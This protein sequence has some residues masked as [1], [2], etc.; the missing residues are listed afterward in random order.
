[1]I[2]ATD[3]GVTGFCT[4]WWG[5]PFSLQ[6]VPHS[7]THYDPPLSMRIPYPLPLPHIPHPLTHFDPA[8]SHA[9]TL[10]LSPTTHPHMP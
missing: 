9:D 6:H 8:P 10:S 4:F 3:C 2:C 7:L 1:M 5:Y